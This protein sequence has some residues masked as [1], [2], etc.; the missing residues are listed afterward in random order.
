MT[1]AAIVQL[2]EYLAFHA[3]E[4]LCMDGSACKYFKALAARMRCE[5][6]PRA[7]EEAV[8]TLLCDPT[9]L[10]DLCDFI[11]EY[12]RVGSIKKRAKSLMTWFPGPKPLWD[13]VHEAR[14]TQDLLFEAHRE[15]NAAERAR[16]IFRTRYLREYERARELEEHSKGTDRERDR[17]RADMERLGELDRRRAEAALQTELRLAEVRGILDLVR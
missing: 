5:G 11:P 7:L 10:R 9:I 8:K 14:S 15:K 16:D 12:R 1:V 6:D 17:D 2:A 3:G 4:S 13:A